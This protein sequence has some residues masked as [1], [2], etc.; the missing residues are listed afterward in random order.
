[1][2]YPMCISA[3]SVMF[4]RIIYILGQRKISSDQNDNQVI[5]VRNQVAIMLIINGIVFLLLHLPVSYATQ[6]RS[7]PFRCD[8]AELPKI[9]VRF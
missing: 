3:T 1:M 6:G 2:C 9:G 5:A 7:Q 4:A 8:G